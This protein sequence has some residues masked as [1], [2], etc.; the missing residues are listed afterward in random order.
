MKRLSLYL[1]L[2]LFTFLTPSLADD[3][4]DFQIEG[5][6]IG[7]SLLDYMTEDEIFEEIELNK[8][9]Y[10]YLNEPDKYAEV[11]IRKEFKIYEYISVFINNKSSSKYLNNKNEK[12]I[13]LGI[14]GMIIY[15][16]DF[17][18]CIQKRDEIVEELSMMLPNSYK[19]EYHLVHPIDPSGNSFQEHV[20]FDFDSGEIV[21]VNCNNFVE[22]FRIK[23]DRYEGLNIQLYNKEITSWM[24][25]RP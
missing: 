14:R 22:T 12:Y 20:S 6:S 2:V 24:R 1:F 15:N 3:I 4:Q 8:Y 19:S 25:N 21:D 13:I 23:H 10:P 17:D 5:M 11:Y 7:D 9:D 18:N 16:E